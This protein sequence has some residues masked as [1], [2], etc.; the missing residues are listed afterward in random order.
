VK[1]GFYSPSFGGNYYEEYE[2]AY[3]EKQEAHK[4]LTL[5]RENECINVT[6]AGLPKIEARFVE[7]IIEE[8]KPSSK[9]FPDS[10]GTNW[11]D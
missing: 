5:C 9:V 10:Y 4:I 2:P 7:K 1:T 11:W 6:L 8:K 3:L